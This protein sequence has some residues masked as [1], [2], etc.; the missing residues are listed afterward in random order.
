MKPRRKGPVA[1]GALDAAKAAAPCLGCVRV[2]RA[3][4]G[5]DPGLIAVLPHSV[6]ILGDH[7][8]FRGYAVLWSRSHAK[9]LHHLGKR[10]YDGLMRDLKRAS[11]A[12]ESAT[13][14]AKLNVVSLGNAVQHAH[15]H[16]FPRSARDP[17]RLEHPW[18]HADRFSAP[19]SAALRRRWVRAI[20][21]RLEAQ[22]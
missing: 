22:T 9:E 13:A 2:S 14:C 18:V 20:R 19:V 3:L 17:R 6:L 7:Q 15:L 4:A 21:A 12:V 8:A 16:L 1:A 5:S 11:A 10:G